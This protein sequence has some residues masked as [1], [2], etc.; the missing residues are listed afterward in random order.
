MSQNPSRKWKKWSRS[1]GHYHSKASERT[2]GDV[3]TPAPL[4]YSSS[5]LD[6]LPEIAVKVAYNVE[7]KK[8]CQEGWDHDSVGKVLATQT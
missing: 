7:T 4:L 3:S 2:P 6:I 8:E 1:D 5:C